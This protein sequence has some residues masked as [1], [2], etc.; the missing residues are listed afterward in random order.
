M[1]FSSKKEIRIK[2][3]YT[4]HDRNRKTNFKRKQII[5]IIVII[6][7]II[8]IIIIIIISI[9]ISKDHDIEITDKWYEHEPETV[10]HNIRITTS[11][12]CETCQSILIEL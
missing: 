1:K 12:S 4:V 8:I 7:I 9:S 10:M 2:P 11:P 3:T 6:T 5:I